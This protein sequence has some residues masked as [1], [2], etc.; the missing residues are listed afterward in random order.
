MIKSTSEVV[1]VAQENTGGM[2][3]LPIES[4]IPLKEEAGSG[5]EQAGRAELEKKRGE[6]YKQAVDE[7]N[8]LVQQITF[9]NRHL[10][11]IIDQMRNIVWEINTM[12]AMRTA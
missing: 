8:E 12:L 7:H 10:K 4:L 11:E 5:L 1:S 3:F 6:Q 2:E 9:K